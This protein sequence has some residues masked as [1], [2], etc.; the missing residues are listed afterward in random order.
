MHSMQ[1]RWRL[2]HRPAL[3]GIRGAA[4]V[5]VIA[6]HAG[7]L[8][9]PDGGI[10]VTLFFVLSGFLITRVI[11]EARDSR[12]WSMA[13]FV[14][15]RF[16]RLFPALAL[17]VAVVSGIL[18]ARGLPV[19]EVTARAVPAL[20]YV[21]NMAPRM[22]YPVFGHTWSLGVEEQ[23]YLLWPLAVPWII[24]R[25]RPQVFLALV[26]AGSVAVEILFPRDWLPMHAYAL[27]AG[28]ALALRRPGQASRWMFPVGA[29]ALA[30]AMA[31]GPTFAQIYVFG[32]MIATPGAVLMVA[33][34]L[35]GN[36]LLEAAPLRLTGR[37]SYAAY[38]WHV[39]LLRLTGTTY[40]RAAAIPPIA[41]AVAIA[42]ASTLIIEE[43]LRRA[44]RSRHSPVPAKPGSLDPTG[45]APST[46]L[47]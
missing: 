14:A 43:P 4:V 15:N 44:W 40:A 28:C 33:G 42:I 2:G 21:Q 29:V 13:G 12:T 39:P 32:P 7:F 24:R 36:R 9:E 10:G 17:M 46:S 22:S 37:I 20:T 25:A 34:A 6:D 41:L 19:R 18:L 1:V 38:L 11:V 30:G 26:I 16:V 35:P 5:I 47:S 8:P 31:L 23:F 27:L 3:D 45:R